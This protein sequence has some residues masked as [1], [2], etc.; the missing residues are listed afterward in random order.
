MPIAAELAIRPSE[1]RA[2]APRPATLKDAFA[3]LKVEH[4]EGWAWV[5]YERVVGHLAERSAAK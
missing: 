1:T 4:N 2:A 5:T 3:L